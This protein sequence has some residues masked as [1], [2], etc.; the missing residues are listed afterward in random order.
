MENISLPLLSIK[1]SA[2]DMMKIIK[3]IYFAVLYAIL[4]KANVQD[5]ISNAVLSEDEILVD[6]TVLPDGTFLVS[7]YTDADYTDDFFSALILTDNTK[8]HP[9]REDAIT[10]T[11]LDTWDED[12]AVECSN[13]IMSNIVGKSYD[14]VL[15]VNCRSSSEMAMEVVFKNPPAEQDVVSWMCL[16]IKENKNV[17][18][19]LT[20][21]GSLA[22]KNVWEGRERAP[23]IALTTLPDY[24]NDDYVTLGCGVI[25]GELATTPGPYRAADFFNP[26]L[27]IKFSGD[28]YARDSY[29]S[30][31][32]V[33]S[34]AYDPDV[35]KTTFKSGLL[36]RETLPTDVLTNCYNEMASNSVV[37]EFESNVT[38][39]LDEKDE[40]GVYLPQNDVIAVQFTDYLFLTPGPF[41][42]KNPYKIVVQEG[43]QIAFKLPEKKDILFTP[44]ADDSSFQMSSKLISKVF[45]AISTYLPRLKMLE[46]VAF[47]EPSS[48][49]TCRS[50]TLD[51]HMIYIS[52]NC[53]LSASDLL[54]PP[55]A[56]QCD[57]ESTR[58]MNF[59]V[60]INK[61]VQNDPIDIACN[62]VSK[63]ALCV[64]TNEF[65][66]DILGEVKILQPKSNP[67]SNHAENV[68]LGDYQTKIYEDHCDSLPRLETVSD[69]LVRFYR[70]AKSECESC[71]FVRSSQELGLI[72]DSDFRSLGIAPG[73]SQKLNM[74]TGKYASVAQISVK[75]PSSLTKKGGE[76]GC[77]IYGVSSPMRS[78]Y[79]S[80]ADEVACSGTRLI[81]SLSSPSKPILI[82]HS[83]NN[84]VLGCTDLNPRCVSKGAPSRAAVQLFG[85]DG[86][87]SEKVSSHTSVSTISTLNDY[88]NV[89]CTSF[90]DTLS[91]NTSLYNLV[92]EI[93]DCVYLADCSYNDDERAIISCYLAISSYC[94]V[95]PFY[96]LKSD[97]RLI[98]SYIMGR[99]V[100]ITPLKDLVY[101]SIDVPAF[102]VPDNTTTHKLTFSGYKSFDMT[103]P[104][105]TRVINL[106]PEKTIG[107]CTDY[108]LPT[109]ITGYTVD[110]NGNTVVTCSDPSFNVPGCQDSDE[111]E[112]V[113]YYLEILPFEGTNDDDY[114]LKKQPWEKLVFTQRLHLGAGDVEW[115]THLLEEPTMFVLHDPVKY[116]I[117]SYIISKD[118]FAQA[119]KNSKAVI[120]RCSKAILSSR[121]TV[122]NYARLD[123]SYVKYKKDYVFPQATLPPITVPTMAHVT[124]SPTT[125]EP[126]VI[127]ELFHLDSSGFL[128]VVIGL[129]IIILVLAL[130]AGYFIRQANKQAEEMDALMSVV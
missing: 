69:F 91:Y 130:L 118:R 73:C 31:T 102:I 44:M 20:D 115:Q 1:L 126:E 25:D 98:G 15:T 79:G 107:N 26:Q 93:D 76:W 90:D 47:D 125:A 27:G 24:S 123:K 67:R 94:E 57:D 96:N 72:S 111:V 62:H 105:F 34:S 114:L 64:T 95:L 59:T 43:K 14:R 86:K 18:Y 45:K 71:S 16:G 128:F 58:D 28:L 113:Q 11:M 117:F 10:I 66:S 127:H 9:N 109:V 103:D 56:A 60:K 88:E 46:L 19:S 92:N 4:T 121:H 8:E 22:H 74:C 122:M 85:K 100:D 129:I 2:N 99:E 101:F 87:E 78:W 53:S 50:G 77:K 106:T 81:G 55:Q 97:G 42:L 40:T 120:A 104:S 12:T 30:A 83:E 80:L 32:H 54:S 119:I 35:A 110:E 49:F 17:I 75:I 38:L 37:K 61:N 63:Y 21:A 7:C 48:S 51:T 29:K 33:C 116:N 52:R 5:H 6:R 84:L 65:T 36:F 108:N 124:V 3:I 89:S 41:F 70:E 13:N 23:V 68:G 112:S 39:F 82:S